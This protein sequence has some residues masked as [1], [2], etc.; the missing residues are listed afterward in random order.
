V[1]R[2]VSPARVAMIA[3]AAAVEG[4]RVVMIA[5][6]AERRESAGR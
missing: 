3:A 4:L 6:A 2:L 5:V 1:R